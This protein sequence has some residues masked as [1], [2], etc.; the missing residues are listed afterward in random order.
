MKKF[1]MILTA[2]VLIVL[3]CAACS[4]AKS[5]DLKA[6]MDDVNASYGL[7]D[8][9]QIEDTDGLNRYYQIAADDVK[10]FAAEIGSSS[11]DYNEIV[12]IEATD[13]NAAD[14]VKQQLEQR[15]SNQLSN[16]KSYAAKQVSMVEACKVKVSGSFVYLV[17][18]DKHAEIEADVEKALQ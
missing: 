14:A 11:T 17:I 18:G 2:A 4:D 7:T 5:V 13:Q 3:L 10:Q 8:L 9:K 6:V 15:L 16:A 1:I 12:L